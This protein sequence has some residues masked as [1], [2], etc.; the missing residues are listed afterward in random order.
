MLQGYLS[1]PVSFNALAHLHGNKKKKKK[2]RA[3]ALSD[4]TV[5]W[6][7]QRPLGRKDSSH[8]PLFFLLSCVKRNQTTQQEAVSGPA[9]EGESHYHP[10][11]QE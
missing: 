8:P 10:R 9:G 6:G 1:A 2:V 11:E 4:C 3:A 7:A 5:G